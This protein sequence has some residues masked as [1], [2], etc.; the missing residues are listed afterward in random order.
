MIDH[1]HYESKN[2]VVIV[3]GAS[4][5]LGL[6]FVRMLDETLPEEYHSGLSREMRRSFGV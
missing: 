3:T 4:S 6:A 1:L 5:G 2:P